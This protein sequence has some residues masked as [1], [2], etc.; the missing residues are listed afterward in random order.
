METENIM[1]EIASLPPKAQKKVIDFVAFLKGCYP[2]KRSVKKQR[3]I[4][5]AD[6]PFIG[7]WRDREE[8]RDSTAW[9][10]N[11]RKSEWRLKL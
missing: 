5:L 6:E 1:R 2:I 8:L 11:L 4:Q 7:M 3:P 9:V 10:K